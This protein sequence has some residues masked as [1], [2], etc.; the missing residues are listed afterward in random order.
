MRWQHSTVQCARIG[1]SARP[2]INARRSAEVAQLRFNEGFS[3]YQ[4]LLDAQQSL[5]AQQSRFV[6]NKSLMIESFI[7]L[8]LSLGGGWELRYEQELIDA[9]TGDSLRERT[10]WGD[11]IETTVDEDKIAHAVLATTLMPDAQANSRFN[12]EPH[13]D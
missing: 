2:S 6:S 13:D 12:D 3:D 8:Y 1:C 10:N 11:M 4:R 7:A 9:D 5:F